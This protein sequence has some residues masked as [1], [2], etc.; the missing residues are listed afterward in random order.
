MTPPAAAL[1]SESAR[2]KMSRVVATFKTN[3][4]NVVAS[5]NE[6]KTLNSNGVRIYKVVSSTITETATLAANRMSIR[7]V[8]SGTRITPTQPIIAT[9]STKSRYRLRSAATFI[10]TRVSVVKVVARHRRKSCSITALGDNSEFGSQ[11]S[12]QNRST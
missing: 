5:S 7:I 11:M 2:V 6:G 10:S 1:E 8:G 4:A 9:G 12:R 3:R